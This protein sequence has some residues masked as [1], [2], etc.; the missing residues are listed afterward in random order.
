LENHATLEENVMVVIP[1]TGSI[2]VAYDL[3]YMGYIEVQ[4]SS[5][6]LLHFTMTYSDHNIVVRIPAEGAESDGV[7]R[8]PALLGHNVLAIFNDDVGSALVTYS[9]EYVS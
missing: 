4:Y 5:P 8:I 3:Q 2:S 6:S 7:I 9:V 1:E